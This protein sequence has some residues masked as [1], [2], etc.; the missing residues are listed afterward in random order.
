MM[1]TAKSVCPTRDL[2]KG[3]GSKDLKKIP[4]KMGH[5]E[6]AIAIDLAT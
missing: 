4:A 2:A 3:A 1:I 5:G 6:E